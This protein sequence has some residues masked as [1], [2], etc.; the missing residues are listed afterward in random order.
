MNTIVLNK[1][2]IPICPECKRILEKSEEADC[3][4]DWECE[5]CKNKYYDSQI[6]TCKFSEL[7][8]D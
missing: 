8:R 4:V 5:Y 2:D 7:R 1:D 6:Y 3:G